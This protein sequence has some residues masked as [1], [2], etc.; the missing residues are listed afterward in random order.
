MTDDQ[1]PAQESSRSPESTPA[2]PTQQQPDEQP[3]E[4]APPDFGQQELTK[5]GWMPNLETRNE[6]SDSKL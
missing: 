1:E 2:Q 3:A 6:G 4:T 5:G